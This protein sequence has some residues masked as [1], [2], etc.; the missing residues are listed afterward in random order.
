MVVPGLV[1]VESGPDKFCGGLVRETRVEM[2]TGLYNKSRVAG[3]SRRRV[4]DLTK[5]WSKFLLGSGVELETPGCTVSGVLGGLKYRMER[6]VSSEIS[7]GGRSRDLRGS[8]K[9]G[10]PE[11]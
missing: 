9:D 10:V 5:E 4:S 7:G 6:G 8:Y 1:V 11:T 3:S 2:G